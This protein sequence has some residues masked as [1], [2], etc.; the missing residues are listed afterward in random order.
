MEQYILTILLTS[1]G[2][3]LLFILIKFLLT[4]VFDEVDKAFDIDYDR[5]IP[6]PKDSN[7]IDH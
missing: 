6:P 3:T 7:Y 4:Q 5:P 2:L 1:I